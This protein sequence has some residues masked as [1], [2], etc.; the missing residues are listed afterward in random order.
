M[1]ISALPTSETTDKVREKS[2]TTKSNTAERQRGSGTIYL[3]GNT[4]W[5]R[6]PTAVRPS[7]KAPL[8]PLLLKRNSTNA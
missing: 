3:R 1:A 6:Y 5:I 8:I 7:A 2:E 4:W